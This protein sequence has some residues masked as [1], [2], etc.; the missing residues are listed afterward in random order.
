MGELTVKLIILVLLIVGTLGA[1]GFL[2]WAHARLM[3]EQEGSGPTP[4]EQ[5]N[6]RDRL[7]RFKDGH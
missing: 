5:S 7:Q 4:V 1:G 2:A 3:R 6:R